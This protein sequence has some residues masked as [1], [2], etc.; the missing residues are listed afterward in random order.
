M[1]FFIKIFKN[2][3][4]FAFKK[5]NSNANIIIYNRKHE[6]MWITNS[7]N[8]NYNKFKNMQN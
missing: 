2:Q 4:Y 7:W 3:N 1:E 6:I 5:F 8:K